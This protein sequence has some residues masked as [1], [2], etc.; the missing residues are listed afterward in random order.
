MM[1]QYYII[2]HAV[3]L[4]FSIQAC[5]NLSIIFPRFL[6]SI[7]IIISILVIVFDWDTCYLDNIICPDM[8]VGSTSDWEQYRHGLVF[9]KYITYFKQDL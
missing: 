7:Y 3:F 5:I 1:G 4:H 9:Y 6:N 8:V 2:V